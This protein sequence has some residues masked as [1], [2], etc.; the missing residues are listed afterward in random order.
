MKINE[1]LRKQIFEIINNQLRD[2]DPPE[3]KKTFDRLQNKGYNEFQTRQMIGQCLAVE[4]FDILKHGK[5]YNNERYVKNLI[6]L[7]KEPFD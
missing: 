5:S 2:N 6:A 4:L 7:P 3:T 1:K